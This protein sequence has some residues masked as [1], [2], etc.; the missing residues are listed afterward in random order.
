[1][2]R[3]RCNAC[4]GEYL[5]TSTD[6]VPYAHVCP[7]LEVLELVDAGGNVTRQ[8]REL[9]AGLVLFDR[10]VDFDAAIAAGG[11]T[12]TFRF[13]KTRDE[14][15]RPGHRDENPEQGELA[16]GETRKRLSEGAGATV[17]E[18]NVPK[19]AR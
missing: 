18:R 1:M 11:D 3:L 6:D 12:S 7:P 8:A 13:V 9:A 2:N 14:R 16:P 15:R 4:R 5:D 19:R 17:L 10:V